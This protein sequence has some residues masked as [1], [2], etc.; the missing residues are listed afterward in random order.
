MSYHF[1]FCPD[2]KADAFKYDVLAAD[3]YFNKMGF[4]PEVLEY[5]L[6][7]GKHATTCHEH[8]CLVMI[9]EYFIYELSRHQTVNR[10]G[11]GK[12][13]APKNIIPSTVSSETGVLSLFSLKS[14]SPAQSPGVSPN[15]VGDTTLTTREVDVEGSLAIFEKLLETTAFDLANH[16]EEAKDNHPRLQWQPKTILAAISRAIATSKQE[17]LQ[18][19][20]RFSML[21]FIGMAGN[22]AAERVTSVDIKAPF[23]PLPSDVEA[24]LASPSYH[25]DSDDEQ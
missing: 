23:A 10:S 3:T 2:R 8:T 22:T 6:E 9:V 16:S 13:K 4:R 12:S 20:R 21:S 15:T 14:T 18:R 5:L 7:A 24:D 19:Q 1:G 17:A 25:A 11:A